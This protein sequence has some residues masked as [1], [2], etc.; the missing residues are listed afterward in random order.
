MDELVKREYQ[1]LAV[2][3]LPDLK[4]SQA[5]PVLFFFVF[6]GYETAAVELDISVDSLKSIIKRTK[7]Q[8]QKKQGETLEGYFLRRLLF[9]HHNQRYPK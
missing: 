9:Y 3:F 6:G 7:I 2:S 4:P 5:L 8:I 1:R